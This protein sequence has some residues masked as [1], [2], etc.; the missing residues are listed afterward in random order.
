M[1]LLSLPK[2]IRGMLEIRFQRPLNYVD[3]LKTCIE[4]ISFHQRCVVGVIIPRMLQ[5][6]FSITKATKSTWKSFGQKY[7]LSNWCPNHHNTYRKNPKGINTKTLNFLAL[8]FWVRG[9]V[10]YVVTWGYKRTMIR[11]YYYYDIIDWVDI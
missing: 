3:I 6:Y 5:S 2:R 9:E 4:L 7:E 8:A 11:N 1:L 10:R